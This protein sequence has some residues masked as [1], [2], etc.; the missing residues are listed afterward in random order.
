[1]L[2]V[3]GSLFFSVYCL[4]RLV[5]RC[6]TRFLTADQ[7]LATCWHVTRRL[8]AGC[9]STPTNCPQHPV[10]KLGELAS[11]RRLQLR[12]VE[13][14]TPEEEDDRSGPDSMVTL[15]ATMGGVTVGLPGEGAS[16]RKARVAAAEG[17]LELWR[18]DADG[19]VADVLARVAK[20]REQAEREARE[21][22]G[23]EVEVQDEVLE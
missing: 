5:T 14:L 9:M 15:Q 10:A 6:L 11:S 4:T 18:E 20:A 1:M 12:F 23:G 22:E 7:C 8:Y 13:V 2:V 16:K 21:A 3:A 17:V 19:L